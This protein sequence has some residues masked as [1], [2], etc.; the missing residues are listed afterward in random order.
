MSEPLSEILPLFPLNVVLFPQSRLHLHIFEERYKALIGE[1]V[2]ADSF[3]GINLLQ[4]SEILTVGCTA[5]VHEVV[6]R[7]EDG[8]MDIVVEG[9]RRYH[10]QN[11]V[12]APHPYHCGRVTWLEDVPEETDEELRITAV[13][14]H[15]EFITTVFTGVVEKVDAADIRKGR[16]FHLVQ[17]CGMDLR[18]R[19]SMLA[20][21]SE[22]QRLRFL[23]RH[24]ET[25]MPLLSSRKSV[26]EFARNDGYIRQ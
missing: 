26:E 17:K 11:I 25:V 12:D 18:Q 10:L 4:E 8:R 2:I 3:F 13:R 6:K 21:R 5:A 14:L 24:L 22:N 16:A 19:Q 15:N 1:T 7:Y 9:R 23:V 20:M